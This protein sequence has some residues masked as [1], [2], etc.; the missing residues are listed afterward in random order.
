MASSEF[1]TE[2]LRVYYHRLFPYAEMTR[3]LAY[4]NDR[5]L[6]G[7][8]ATYFQR[9]EFSFTL[10]HDIYV[11]YQSF[12]DAADMAAVVRDKCPHKIDIGAV[13]NVDV[14]RGT[15]RMAVGLQATLC[16]CVPTYARVCVCV[17]A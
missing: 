2:F 14:S 4:G 3:W 9:R 11:R 7:S 17:R 8:D 6:P 10:E 13:Y 1:C 12:K 5:K 16:P 15:G